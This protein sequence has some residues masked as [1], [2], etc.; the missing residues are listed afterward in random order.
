MADLTGSAPATGN[1]IIH[2]HTGE[3]ATRVSVPHLME[4]DLDGPTLEMLLAA[5]T[6]TDC[7]P[8]GLTHS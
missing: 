7:D 3:V 5:L 1:T 8:P 2:E 6:V 4:L